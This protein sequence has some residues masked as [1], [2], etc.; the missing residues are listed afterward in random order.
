MRFHGI[1]YDDMMIQNEDSPG[2]SVCSFRYFHELF[3]YLMKKQPPATE[4]WKWKTENNYLGIKKPSYHAY[5]FL[6]R[7]KGDIIEQGDGYIV[8]DD[9]RTLRALLWNYCHHTQDMQSGKGGV[10]SQYNL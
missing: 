10:V 7:L 9:S 2:A 1:F 4:W 8:A 6:H 3:D 5:A